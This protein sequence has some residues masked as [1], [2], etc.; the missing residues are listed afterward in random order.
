MGGTDIDPKYY[1]ENPGKF[2]QPP[3]T[4]RDI[5]EF[6]AVNR[7]VQE[8]QPVVGVCR[9]AQLLCVANGGT[10]HQHTVPLEDNHSITTNKG[11]VFEQVAAD[12]HQ[13]MM[14]KGDYIVLAYNPQSVRIYNTECT[15]YFNRKNTPEVIWYPDTKCLAIQPHP[16]WMDST[17]PFNVWLNN[18][19]KELEIDYEF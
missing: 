16:E 9:G 13:I 15:E 7:A 1:D 19:M 6:A 3:D 2:T 11:V 4:I 18:L 17:H 5:K 10:L 14:P 8:G 12:H